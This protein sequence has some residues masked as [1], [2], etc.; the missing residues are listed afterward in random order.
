MTNDELKDQYKNF[1][2]QY[3]DLQVQLNGWK[4]AFADSVAM[5]GTLYKS[6]TG[7]DGW[8]HTEALFRE[9][10]D[11]RYQLD[12]FL[13]AEDGRIFGISDI[14]GDMRFVKVVFDAVPTGSNW[15]PVIGIDIRAA[16]RRIC[17]RKG[18]APT[19]VEIYEDPTSTVVVCERCGAKLE[20]KEAGSAAEG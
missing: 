4:I 16:K 13:T 11:I 6:A 19:N 9:C 5:F 2:N 7:N 1:C 20:A 15:I 18:C 17:A 3:D 10:A 12:E 14:D 8:A